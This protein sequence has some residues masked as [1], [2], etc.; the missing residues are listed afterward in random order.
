[1]P[2]GISANSHFHSIGDLAPGEIDGN[3]IVGGNLLVRGSVSFPAIISFVEPPN[4][5]AG[6]LWVQP[7][8]FDD[9][10]SPGQ[11]WFN[12]PSQSGLLGAI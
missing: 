12:Y 6:M 4:P 7:E 2:A 1:M 8:I 9:M 3:L 11:L 10:I 5:V